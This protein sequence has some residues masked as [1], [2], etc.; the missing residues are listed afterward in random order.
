MNWLMISINDLIKAKWNY[1]TDDPEKA[2]AL[3]NNINKNGQIE[4]IIVRQVGNKYEVING[5]HRLDVFKELLYTKVYCYNLGIITDSMAK[6]ISIE[7]NETKFV[8]DFIKL[9]GLIKDLKLDFNFDDLEKTM[10]FSKD[11]LS[12]LIK[13]SEFD[14][15]KNKKNLLD[16]QLQSSDNIKEGHIIKCPECGHEWEV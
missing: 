2:E 14:F 15:D 8:T 6:R 9:G 13:L 1:K 4:N 10:P 11:E 5:N 7:T 3:K 12:K 16:N